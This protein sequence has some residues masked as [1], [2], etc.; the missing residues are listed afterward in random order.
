MQWPVSVTSPVKVKLVVTKPLRQVMMIRLKLTGKDQNQEFLFVG[1]VVIRTKLMKK[2]P[3]QSVRFIEGLNL[4]K[5]TLH[6]T[7]DASEKDD[8]E[9][10]QTK[11]D[12]VM[13]RNLRRSLKKLPKRK[14]L[15][16]VKT[17][18]V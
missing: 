15:Q 8:S 7:V 18:S 6:C 11:R 16:K 4:V 2:G 12:K 14:A 17:W 13:R 5:Q 3:G 9:I 10:N 1:G